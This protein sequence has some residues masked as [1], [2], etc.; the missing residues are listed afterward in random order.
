MI[1]SRTV[2]SS[3]GR[4]SGS[5]S[6]RRISTRALLVIRVVGVMQRLDEVADGRDVFGRQRVGDRAGQVGRLGF[7]VQHFRFGGRRIH[8]GYP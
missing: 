6:G 4:T 8:I 3:S 1:S 2:S 5:N 7:A